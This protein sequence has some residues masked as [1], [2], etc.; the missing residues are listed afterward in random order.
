MCII[1]CFTGW[2]ESGNLGGRVPGWRDV[3]RNASHYDKGTV[4]QQSF[5]HV[6]LNGYGLQYL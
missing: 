5:G 1:T 3:G 4:V 2:Y 6:F